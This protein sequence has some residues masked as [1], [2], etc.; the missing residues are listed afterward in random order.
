[1]EPFG[2][3]ADAGLYRSKDL[4]TF[5]RFT[6]PGSEIE[7]NTVEKILEDDHKNLWISTLQ[8]IIKLNAARNEIK[9]YG[10]THGVNAPN[11]IYNAGC[12]GTNGMLYFGDQSGYYSLSPELLTSNPN[13][14][15]IVITQFRL[16]DQQ[17]KAENIN[18]SGSL[19]THSKDI[20]LGHS[21]KCIF[22]RFCSHTLQQP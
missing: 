5:S 19:L 20:I 10:K 8:G 15:Q 11:F 21:P 17:S 13:P 3:E 14:P 12:K 9:I 18:Q 1:M 7:I 2:W 4:N 6:L 16:Q 22:H